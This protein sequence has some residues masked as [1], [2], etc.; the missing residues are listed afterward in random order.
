MSLEWK[1][2]P[3]IWWPLG[4]QG[5]EDH[6]GQWETSQEEEAKMTDAAWQE[7]SV[8]SGMDCCAALGSVGPPSFAQ[9]SEQSG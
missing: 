3:E 6:T 5:Q 7:C 4:P 1:G 2:D 8:Q 9:V